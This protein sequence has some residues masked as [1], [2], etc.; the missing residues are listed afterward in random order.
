LIA[1]FEEGRDV[2]REV[3]Y[4]TIAHFRERGGLI[5]TRNLL[6]RLRE[7]E[8]LKVFALHVRNA[9]DRE[10]CARWFTEQNIDCLFQ[11]VRDTFPFPASWSISEV[12][13]FMNRVL[14]RHPYELES[15]N[16]PRL[17]EAGLWAIRHWQIDHV[18]FESSIAA[19]YWQDLHKI[20]VPTTIVTINREAELF[21]QAVDNG[22]SEHTRW[23]GRIAARRFAH[24][25]RRMFEPL[26]RSSRS[27]RLICHSTCR[28][29]SARL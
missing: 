4:F 7:D 20:P 22:D 10:S 27:A 14:F 18:V 24:R 17:A 9:A 6:Q 25:E 3:L 5:Y 1:P 8:N 15:Y 19:L 28:P 12:A 23:S 13:S 21:Q 2:P 29:G 11:P 26:A 16:Q